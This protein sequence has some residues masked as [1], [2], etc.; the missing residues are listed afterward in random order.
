[1][2]NVD[3]TRYKR[4]VQYFWDPEPRNNDM[5]DSSIW[6]LGLEYPSDRSAKADV[7]HY[8]L[9]PDDS[10]VL[11]TATTTNESG[12]TSQ[13]QR[14]DEI[15]NAWPKEFLLD[16]E[17]KIWM[18]YRSRFPPI[19]RSEDLNATSSMS[20]TTRLRSQLGDSEGF[21]ADTGWGCMI[22]SGQSLLAN[23]LIVR[24]LGR[25]QS[26]AASCRW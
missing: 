7:P 14:G 19:P 17:S 1:M 18:T 3:L 12:P 15:G 25:G 22:R 23:T 5:S 16:F 9:Q 21:T 26:L 6:C 2:N 13:T 20:F 4:I 8:T 24:S 10:I 11:V